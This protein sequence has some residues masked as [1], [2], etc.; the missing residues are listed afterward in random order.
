[1]NSGEVVVRTIGSDLRMDYT[2]VGQTTHLA[3]RM[4]Q[5]ATGGRTLLTADTLRLAE[6]Y[7]EVTP[8]GPIPVKGLDARVEIHELIGAGARRSRLSAAAARG[9]T[10]FVGRDAELEQLRQALGRAAA[11]HG[12][13]VAIVG[14][15]GV[16][17]SRIV[18]EVTHSHRVHGW[19]VLQ[20]GS[21]SYGKATSYL[22]VI[23]LLKGYFA[24][25]DRDGPRMVREKLTGRLLTLDRT[26]EASLP[27]LLALLDVPTGDPS[28]DGLDPRHRRQRTLHAVKQLLIRESQVQPLLV[29]FEDLHW[30]DSETQ[31]LLDGLVESL[32]AARFLLLVNYRPEYVHQWGS[33]T[34]YTQL[35]LDPLP[36][37]TAD[38]LLGALLG[39]DAGLEPLRRMLIARTEGNPF[40]LEESVQ[41]LIETEALSGE[42][43]AYRLARPLPAIQVPAT[44]QAILAARIDRLAPGDKALLQ[45]ASVIGKDVPFVLLQATAGIPEDELRGSIGRLQAAEFLYETRLF[46][47]L[48]YTFKHA[49]THEVAY[50][51]LLQDRRRR[52]HGEILAAIERLYPDRLIEHIDRLGNHALR[53]EQWETAADYLRQAGHKAVS[54][55]AF[56]EAILAYDNALAAIEHF[57]ESRGRQ[58]QAIDLRLDLRVPL[59]AMTRTN[60]LLEG[61]RAAES[62]ARTLGDERRLGRISSG[63][64]NT[65]WITGDHVAAIVAASRALEIGQRLGDVATHATAV[66]RLGAIHYTLGEYETAAVYLRQGLQL[67]GDEWLRERFGM[68]STASVVARHWLARTLAE[69]G[70]F[71]EGLAVAQEGLDTALF[72][73]FVGDLPPALSA[74]GYVHLYRG[75]TLEALA[76]LT[77]AV[78]IGRATE[79]LNWGTTALGLLGLRDVRTERSVDGVGLVERASGLADERGERWLLSVLQMWL[80]EVHLAAGDPERARRDAQVS[81]EMSRAQSQRGTEAWA[82]W[83]LAEIAAATDPPDT[84]EAEAAYREALGRASTLGMRPLVAHCYLG[85]GKLYRRTGDDAMAREHLTTATTMYRETGMT[86]WLEQAETEMGPAHGNSP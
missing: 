11:G 23:D 22:P 4:E 8:L 17:K 41:A 52:L 40:F 79:F 3:A 12:Q 13:V 26:H 31:A 62:I 50:G 43:G 68:T 73:G 39:S 83:L 36:P 15:P 78:E 37:E 75:D 60:R 54:R 77:R 19:L 6:G 25:E 35:R 45:T 38:E 48:E 42:H 86:F 70:N 63:L 47:D 49:L 61:D 55:S 7:V 32:P 72:T 27:P 33:R 80:G 58:E 30:V 5:L 66:L 2:A 59:Q 29:V 81:L 1:L 56:Q 18:W 20:A 71:S 51:S 65:L 28:W 67:I 84:Q 34:Y 53:A 76:P 24:I 14:E 57:P 10:R 64:A 9:L 46:P 21:V 85:L 69:L 16:G 82:W 44:V 74:V